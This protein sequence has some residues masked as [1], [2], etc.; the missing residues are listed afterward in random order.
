METN[1]VLWAVGNLYTAAHGEP[2]F[3]TCDSGVADDVDWMDTPEEQRI[4]V[5]EIEAEIERIKNFEHP[6]LEY[7][8]NRHQSYPAIGDQLDA[9]F[10]AGVFPPEMAAQIQTVKDQFPKPD[11]NI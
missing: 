6:T 5:G 2:P 11:A 7:M 3:I 10:H 1:Y 8:K 4:S 9:L